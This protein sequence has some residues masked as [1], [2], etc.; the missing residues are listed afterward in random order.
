MR[1]VSWFFQV[2]HGD[3]SKPFVFLGNCTAE[4]LATVF[5]PLL[6]WLH[7]FFVI[8]QPVSCQ[9]SHNCSSLTLQSFKACK[10]LQLRAR[11]FFGS[12]QAYGSPSIA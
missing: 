9:Q 4:L 8:E 7:L 6:L 5:V 3:A 11:Q 1:L 12:G 10:L 2:I